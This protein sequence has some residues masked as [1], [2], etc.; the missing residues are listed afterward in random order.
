METTHKGWRVEI[1]TNKATDAAGWRVYAD[2]SRDDGG[3]VRTK[4]LS[5]G[6]SRRKSCSG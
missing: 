4:P 1:R 5:F 6:H 2:V 3:S